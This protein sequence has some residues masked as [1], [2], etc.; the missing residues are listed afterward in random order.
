[1][2]HIYCPEKLDTTSDQTIT[3][4]PSYRNDHKLK[5]LLKDS[6]KINIKKEVWNKYR[7]DLVATLT[8]NGHQHVIEKPPRSSTPLGI[9]LNTKNT[10]P[11]MT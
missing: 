9:P 2:K 8:S 3:G 6:P 4:Y 1:M 7:R 5:I 10:R 11:I